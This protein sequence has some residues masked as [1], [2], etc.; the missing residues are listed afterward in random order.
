MFAFITNW[1]HQRIISRSTVPSQKWDQVINRMPLLDRLNADEKSRLVKL[2]ILF[3][4]YKV[5]EGAHGLEVTEDMLLTISLQACLPILNLGF[6]WYDGWKSVIVYPAQF[7]PERIY[8]D[9]YGVEHRTR[10]VLSGESWHKGPV[11]LSWEDSEYAGQIDGYNVVI[12]EFAHKLDVLNGVTNGFPPLH[13]SMDT[14]SWAQSF[15]H[16]YNDLRDRIR[17]GEPIAIDHYAATSPAEFFAV[18][19][20]VFFEKPQVLNQYYPEIYKLYKQFYRQD[21]S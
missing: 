18:L 6:D 8:Q 11:V 17:Y 21:L 3:I 9:E 10:D 4:H 13:K 7:I 16:A 2:A 1:N 5:I 15:S 20:E 12:H 14:S 19:S